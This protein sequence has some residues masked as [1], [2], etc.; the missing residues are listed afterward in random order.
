M[1]VW[2]RIVIAPMLAIASCAVVNAQAIAQ[3]GETTHNFGRFHESTGNQTCKFV[4]TNTGDSALIITRVQASCG[5]TSVKH[6]TDAI[7]P[8]DSGVVDVTF[9]PT[10]RPGP[11]EKSVWVFTNTTPNKTRLIIN[12]SVT[13]SAE[14]VKRYYPVDAGDLQF[15][16]LTMALGETKKGAAP[17]YSTA[18]Y[19][20]GNDTIALS[21]DNTTSHITYYAIPDTIPPGHISTITYFFNSLRTK[22][23]GINDDYITIIATPLHSDK[24]PTK[25][26]ANIV[27]N[28]VEDFSKLSDEDRVNAPVCS[29][30]NKIVMGESSSNVNKQW[31]GTVVLRNNGKSD[32]IVRRVMTLDKAITAESNKTTLKPNEQAEISIRVNPDKVSGNVLNSHITIITNDPVNPHINVRVVGEIKK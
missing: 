31:E 3:W 1:A 6:T 16:T 13:G 2:L 20:T 8:G 10:G 27:A 7:M 19:N 15:T 9:S 12:G 5:C 17:S 30:P 21:F 22:V 24:A 11:F 14:T 26:T 32:L 18:A 4:V 29:I 28:V 23:W 25:I